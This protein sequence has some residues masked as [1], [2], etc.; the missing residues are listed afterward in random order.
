M[1]KLLDLNVPLPAIK[2]DLVLMAI[3]TVRI[4]RAGM[5]EAEIHDAIC[6]ELATHCIP[7]KR[8]QAFGP[9][10]RAD[11]WVDGIVVEVKKQRPARAALLDQISRYA[12]Q[13]TVRAIVI[14]LERSVPLPAT[15]NDK[16]IT[17]IS[18]NALWGIAL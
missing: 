2:L 8:E 4:A 7:H 6:M 9:R 10:C 11:I 18:L 17:I 15:L 12:A 1:T 3:R 16:P 14:V 13:P 5:P